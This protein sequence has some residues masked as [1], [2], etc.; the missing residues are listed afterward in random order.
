MTYRRPDS[1]EARLVRQAPVGFSEAH[2]LPGGWCAYIGKKEDGSAIALYERE[3]AHVTLRQN[4]INTVT[5]WL[6][7]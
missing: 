7:S 2:D 1:L 5:R 6:A 4:S 3:I